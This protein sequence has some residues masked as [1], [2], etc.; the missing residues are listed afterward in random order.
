MKKAVFLDRD[1]CINKEVHH[2]HRMDQL[3]ILPRVVEAIHRLNKLDLFV[4][5]ITNQSAVAHG[6]ASREEI[7]KIHL[8]LQKRLVNKL[9]KID[10]IYYCPHHPE[11]KIAIYKIKCKCRKPETGLIKKA[12]KEFNIDLKK[13]FMIGDRTVDIL[14]GQKAGL[15]TILVKTGYGGRDAIYKIEP[16]YTAKNLWEAVKIIEKVL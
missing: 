6:L 8:T 16:D 12:A 7:E 9:A 13:S 14:T 4:V 5:V 15:K 2:L 1:G 10:A 3:R 11:G